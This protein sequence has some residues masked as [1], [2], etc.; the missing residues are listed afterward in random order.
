MSE[1]KAPEAKDG[2]DEKKEGGGGGTNKIVV[3]ML[4]LLL[5]V[6][7]GI[8]GFLVWIF[9]I[10]KSMPMAGAA[11]PPAAAAA[12]HGDEH[13]E[14]G[15]EGEHAEGHEDSD[16]HGDEE[17]EEDSHA[18]PPVLVNIDTVTAN[19]AVAEGE[20]PAYIR[21]TMALGV[22]NAAA[23]TLVQE[24]MIPIKDALLVFFRGLAYADTQ[25]PT[26]QEVIQREL[27]TRLNAMFGRKRPIKRIYFTEF[28][29]QR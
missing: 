21:V 9:A 29:V 16:G 26:K 22:K 27:T 3:I 17:E 24:R 2:K 28:V 7:L 8:V 20:E 11:P 4:A 23:Q 12:Q 1:E 25:G 18:R 14:E 5:V 15:E 10:Q 13:G 19:L 6:M